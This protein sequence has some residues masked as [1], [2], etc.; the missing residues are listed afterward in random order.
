MQV[1]GNNKISKKSTVLIAVA[2]ASLLL[3]QFAPQADAQRT[4]TLRNPLIP[5]VPNAAPLE[6]PMEG[7]P[8]PVGD[9]AGPA[10]VT[11]G[12]YGYIPPLPQIRQTPRSIFG[13]G[14]EVALPSPWTLAPPEALGPSVSV[15]PPP[16]TPGADPGVI[17]PGPNN[18]VQPAACWV[19]ICPD[20]GMPGDFAP[21]QRRAAQ[22]TRD[23][24]LDRDGSKL[25]DFGEKLTEKP[26]LKMMPQFSEDGPRQAV[27]PGRLGS[28]TNRATGLPGAQGTRD[29]GRR[30]MFKQIRSRSTI[31][32]F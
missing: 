10:P 32:P 25:C 19:N 12:D 18:G 5:C 7:Q 28:A 4:R 2:F 9:G 21:R 6:A 3:V 11:P 27:F 15:P 26:D 30:V 17:F 31:A 16:S 8:P 20:G 29:I 24:G 22:T 13:G 14:E 1:A 23:L